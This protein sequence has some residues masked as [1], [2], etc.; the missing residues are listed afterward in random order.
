MASLDILYIILGVCVVVVTVT[1]VWV[2]NDLMKL[3]RSLRHSAQDTET[4]TREI[5]EKVLLVSESLDRLGAAASSVI[6]LIEDSVETI[7]EKR[8]QIVG[9]IGLI[10]GASDFIKK[11]RKAKASDKRQVASNKRKSEE[12]KSP[13]VQKE[14]GV[15][16]ETVGKKKTKVA[17]TTEDVGKNASEEEPEKTETEEDKK[18]DELNEA[19]EKAENEPEEKEEEKKLDELAKKS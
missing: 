13:D 19:K 2:A 12:K 11:R 16:T 14:V 18:L 8:D 17:P 9:S 5:K 15:L 10:T 4:V 1:I 6:G 7:K 3:I